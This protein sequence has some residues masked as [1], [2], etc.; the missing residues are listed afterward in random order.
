M[1]ETFGVCPTLDSQYHKGE[2]I[3]LTDD[4]QVKQ[5]TLVLVA[6]F[7]F[8]LYFAAMY[9]NS[10]EFAAI[11]FCVQKQKTRECAMRD[12]ACIIQV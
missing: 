5:I 6:R 11:V 10:L 4:C 2:M 1:G 3:T 9:S 8:Q 7:I 12:H